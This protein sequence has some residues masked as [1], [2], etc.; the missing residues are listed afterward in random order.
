[1]RRAKGS[2]AYSR[3]TVAHAPTWLT[4]PTILER[5]NAP[6]A[7]IAYALTRHVL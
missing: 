7:R 6:P 3:A 5:A 1:M 2:A 4:T